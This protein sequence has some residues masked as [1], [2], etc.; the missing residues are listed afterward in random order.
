MSIILL[1]VAIAVV[2]G[3]CWKYSNS[4]IKWDDK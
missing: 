3:L 1:V 2:I 4:I